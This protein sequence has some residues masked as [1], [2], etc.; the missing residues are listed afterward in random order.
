[1][2][3]VRSVIAYPTKKGRYFFYLLF[4]RLTATREQ[5]CPEKEAVMSA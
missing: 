3:L 2:K 1:M 5:V 4:H